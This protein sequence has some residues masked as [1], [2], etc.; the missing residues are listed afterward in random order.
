MTKIQV[1]NN[2]MCEF[3]HLKQAEAKAVKLREHYGEWLERLEEAR[4]PWCSDEQMLDQACAKL[5]HFG[6]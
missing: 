6:P 1:L 2:L 3:R 5:Q 4:P